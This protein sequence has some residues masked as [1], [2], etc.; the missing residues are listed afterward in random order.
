MAEGAGRDG[1]ADRERR[2]GRGRLSSLELLPPEAEE[3]VV[4]ARVELAKRERSQADILHDF[5]GRLVDKGLEPVSKSAFNRASVRLAAM[6]KRLTEARAFYDSMG[7]Q[8]PEKVDE[9]GAVLSEM[10]K[11]LIFDL[12]QNEGSDIGPTGAKELAAAHLAVIRGQ[13]ISTERRRRL[14]AD[15]KAAA[16][17]EVGKVAD[18]LG[19]SAEV[20]RDLNAELF[21]VAPPA[22]RAPV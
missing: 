2:A 16:A 7:V 8:S 3:D 6:N 11:L 17:K 14:E 13:A 19:L 18:K 21:G 12:V 20:R 1:G 5:N 15:F 4:W 22:P 9:Q 10:L